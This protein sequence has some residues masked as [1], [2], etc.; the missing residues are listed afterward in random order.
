NVSDKPLKKES[1]ISKISKLFLN[2]IAKK[3]AFVFSISIAVLGFLIV[4]I[5]LKSIQFN[6]E[7]NSLLNNIF[8]IN[9]IRVNVISQPNKILNSCLAGDS[10]EEGSHI[11][12]AKSILTFMD[13]LKADLESDNKYFGNL[14]AIKAVR[15]PAEKYVSY[16]QEIY[17]KSVDGKFPTA[18]SDVQKIVKDMGVV[19]S[20]ISNNLSSLLTLEL[21]R[22]SDIQQE[23]EKD[24]RELIVMCIIIFAVAV[25]VS[26]FLFIII[27][28]RI[29]TSIK[30]LKT[31]FIH[32]SEGDLSR[33]KVNIRSNDEVEQLAYN[34]NIMSDNLKSIISNVRKAA[35]EIKEV[36]QVVTRTTIENEKG[37][38]NIAFAL[39]NMARSMDDQRAE[40]DNAL[41]MMKDIQK[42]SQDVNEKVSDISVS[43]A[44]ALEK[45]EIGNVKL[46]EYM[47]Q[48][49]D[50]NATMEEVAQ[51]SEAFVNQTHEMNKI[52]DSIR[53]ISNQTNLLSLNAS[54]EAARAGDA[55][56]G[57][58][59]VADEI[60]KLSDSSEELVEK[61]AKIVNSIQLSLTEMKQK[62][63]NGLSELEKSNDMANITMGSFRD[64][65]DA[66]DVECAMALDIKRMMEELFKGITDIAESMAQIENATN[67]NTVVSQD[68]SATVEEETANLEEV[69]SKMGFLEDLTKNLEDLVLKFKL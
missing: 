15:D 13:E 32:M 46:S 65:K 55:G 28:R 49:K 34:F 8:Q 44:N 10:L 57:F 21:A 33:E 2:S 23:F 11:E 42:I 52:L 67:E 50:V 41:I 39:E 40:T 62:L 43:A 24:F 45:A 18:D 19:G 16:I 22:S 63:S 20:Q 3:V 9:E 38:E 68:I 4:F 66:N 30:K 59:V 1:G 69:A 14:G 5:L 53:D 29:T 54:I 61:I 60:R 17:D 47:V 6:N 31:E 56:R 58:A 25:I 36:T 12:S 35:L 51:V 7:Y 37:S 64:I 48:L 27:I 26:L